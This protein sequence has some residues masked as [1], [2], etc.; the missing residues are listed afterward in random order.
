M[1]GSSK[2]KKRSKKSTVSRFG[3]DG[4]KPIEI[5]TKAETLR[6]MYEQAKVRN[7]KYHNTQ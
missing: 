6:E 1:I 5:K 2:K 4:S 3:G 7:Q